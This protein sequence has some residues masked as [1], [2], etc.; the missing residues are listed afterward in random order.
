MQFD[1]TGAYVAGTFFLGI[2]MLLAVVFAVNL[3]RAELGWMKLSRRTR[4][5]GF[6]VL[7]TVYLA[8]IW[9]W[10]FAARFYELRVDEQGATVNLT[11][12]VPERTLRLPAI[13]IEDSRVVPSPKGRL[14]QLQIVTSAGRTYRSPELTGDEA[15]HLLRRLRGELDV[16]RDRFRE[17]N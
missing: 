12:L 11:F 16:Q 7:S 9:S 15:S 8:V 6:T 13:E 5:V 2:W 4:I 10:L 1:S 3:R 14:R 17:Q